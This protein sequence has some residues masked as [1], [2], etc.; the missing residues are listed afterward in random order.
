[1][2]DHRVR[3]LA[4]VEE[5]RKN[6]CKEEQ[7]NVIEEDAKK[8]EAHLSHVMSPAQFN[9]AVTPMSPV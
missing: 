8:K 6:L 7:L 2:N 3:P 4:V 1:M 5:V 9:Q